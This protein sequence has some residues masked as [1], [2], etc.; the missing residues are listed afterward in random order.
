M[1]RVDPGGC[2]AGLLCRN[3]QGPHPGPDPCECVG[4]GRAGGV[5]RSTRAHRILEAA[6]RL[7]PPPADGGRHHA[8][9]ATGLGPAGVADAVASLVRANLVRGVRRLAWHRALRYH[10]PL[11]AVAQLQPPIG[12][13]DVDGR[14]CL[15][16]DCRDRVAPCCPVGDGT[17][18]GG[19]P[20]RTVAVGLTVVAGGGGCRTGRGCAGNANAALPVAPGGGGGDRGGSGGRADLLTGGDVRRRAARRPAV[21]RHLSTRP[22][23]SRPRHVHRPAAHGPRARIVRDRRFTIRR[24]G[25]RCHSGGAQRAT[26]ST[27][28]GWPGVRPPGADGVRIRGALRGCTH[29]QRR[30]GFGV[31]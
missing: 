10:L 12:G 19:R 18:G 11:L 27:R 17:R 6:D 28:G 21:H 23:G 5:R 29:P 31:S 1:G 14:R 26:G 20:V 9:L 4:S 8:D 24:P 30:R 15:R 25:S 2:T 13:G 3:A 22:L 7:R 16:G